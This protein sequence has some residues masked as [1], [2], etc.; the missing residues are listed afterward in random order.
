MNKSTFF[1]FF[2]SFLIVIQSYSQSN[3]E[4]NF[5]DDI[6]LFRITIDQTIPNNIWQIGEPGKPV[7]QFSY[8]LFNAMVTYLQNPYPA[9]NNS[10]FYLVT[11][12]GKVLN[13]HGTRL[14]FWYQM[15]TDTLIDYGKIEIAFD[16]SQAWHN[17]ITGNDYFKVTD[18]EGNTLFDSWSEDTLIFN[19]TSGGW[20]HFEYSMGLPTYTNIDTIR[21]RFTFHS[22]SVP[23]N[24][25]GWMID[26]ISFWYDYES[27]NDKKTD[28]GIYPNPVNDRM[29]IKTDV[30]IFEYEIRNTTGLLIMRKHT[31]SDQA[32]VNVSDLIPGMYFCNITLSD[33]RKCSKKF[34]KIKSE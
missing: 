23:T 29:S 2:L 22:S 5:E 25:D 14:S 30:P 20:Y 28:Y 9:D 34:I 12:E 33:G 21:Y 26:D 15:D 17:I 16:S 18:S 7:F 24:H 19:G 3:Q 13:A 31:V 4:I 11:N 8:S 32:F 6:N 10:V 27:T 1:F